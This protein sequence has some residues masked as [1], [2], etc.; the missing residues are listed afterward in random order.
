MADVHMGEPSVGP[1]DVVTG[2][3][4]GGDITATG[5]GGHS[6]NTYS[7]LHTYIRTPHNK[8]Q[9]NMVTIRL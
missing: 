7:T 5:G 3:V 2:T 8:Q 1:S 6:R 4:S 9:R